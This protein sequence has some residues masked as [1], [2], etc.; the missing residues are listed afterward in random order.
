MAGLA[1]GALEYL[2]TANTTD[3]EAAETRV[4]Q[5]GQR[6]ESNPAQLQVTADTTNALAGMD[7]VETA[8]RQIVSQD[9]V[10]RVE[11]D[12]SQAEGEAQRIRDD[13]AYLQSIQTS[14][15]V[16]AD[17]ARAEDRLQRVE[18]SLTGLNS[19]RATM[20]VAADTSGAES[21]LSDVAD[22]AGEAG[23]EGGEAAGSNLATGIIDALGT[24][25]VAGAVVGVGAA[26][27]VAL[28]KGM[29]GALDGEVQ[30]DT[31]QAM[32]GIDEESAAR[33][34]RASGE[35]YANVFGE[36]IESNMDTARIAVQQGLLDPTATVRQSQ[37]LIEAL[38]GVSGILMEDVQPVAR[39]T[40][41]LLRTGLVKTADEAFD[42]IVKGQ[43]SGANAAEDWLDTLNEYAPIWSRLGLSGE[44]A[45][46]LVSQ[47]LAAGARDSDIAAD[48]LKEFQIRATDAS[49][50]SADAYELIG[51]SAEDM[52]T[53]ISA[54]GEGAREGLDQ[55]LDG[56][57]AI[58]DPVVRNTAAVGLFGTQA[59]D[60]GDALYAL[61]LS[62]AVEQLGQVEGAAKSA[63]DTIGDN[64]ASDIEE[65]QRNIEVAA[66]GIKGALAAAFGEPLEDMANYVSDNRGVVMQFLLDL[67][68]GGLDMGRHFVEG[69]A[70]ATEATGMFIAGPIA[71][72]V[73][74]VAS[75]LNGLDMIPGVDTG[76]A[77]SSMR[78]L[79]ETLRSADTAA[80]D[81]ADSIRH[82]LIEN[83]IDPAQEKLNEFGD[84]L[85][86]DA[87][88]HD[89]TAAWARS[90]DAVGY[91]AATG[92]ALVGAFTEAQD[93]SLTASVELEQQLMAAVSALDAE[94]EAG[95]R[96]GETQETLTERYNAGR[97][98]L[99]EQLVQMGATSEQAQVL[100]D[101]YLAV[102]GGVNTQITSN[103][104]EKI[105]QTD[106][107]SL[108]IQQLPDGT[109]SVT[110]SGID[111]AYTKIMSLQTA[112]RTITGDKTVR[113]AT[114]PGGQGGLTFHDGGIAEL[115]A[116]G[117]VRG[118][119][120]MQP[121]AQVVSPNTWRIVG[122]R[123]VDDEAYIPI[124]GSPRSHAIL[125]ETMR[126]MGVAPMAAG[127]VVGTAGGGGFDRSTAD[128]LVRNLGTYLYTLMS[129]TGRAV[130]QS[131]RAYTD[132]TLAGEAVARR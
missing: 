34:G 73:D 112:I 5:I 97:D 24:I 15:E 119:T 38:S 39:A 8:A 44:E 126:R 122:D 91:S 102:P 42:I 103:A 54:G 68:N 78:D 16:T 92:S 4:R 80:E 48:A 58:E 2:F 1:A 131:A 66:T 75:I 61:D 64:T 93:G 20:E 76:D 77:E 22:A 29:E 83:G 117:G 120:P 74:G 89:A 79:A 106:D 85:V 56:L 128:Y 50:A 124:D 47:G 98:A 23:E 3:V 65:A 32:T 107:L 69:I 62:N 114:G 86:A 127:A 118:L 45:L 113:I 105:A 37:E 115:M 27:G 21:A 49:E 25:P 90:L 18:R 52:T 53:K 99:I 41:Q 104:G 10:A 87:K 35:A 11:A 110:A 88:F 6:V 57:R 17:I 63:M 96:A 95:A 108:K 101:R 111:T 121:I 31:L 82:N 33:L 55:V 46:G 36:S 81:A 12:I 125:A 84:P 109:F 7:R 71:D 40:V 132:S 67:A 13:L 94:A 123:A 70:V 129:G 72:L 26:I 59:E 60:M 116:D 43:Q 30:R 51:L 130:D 14:V 100:A 28:F 19:A 9:I